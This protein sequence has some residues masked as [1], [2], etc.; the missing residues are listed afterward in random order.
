MHV[1]NSWTRLHVVFMLT[2]EKLCCHVGMKT[3]PTT[4]NQDAS[5]ACTDGADATCRVVFID[6]VP[7]VR[8]GAGCEVWR[9]HVQETAPSR[10]LLN[11][12]PGRLTY[13]GRSVYLTRTEYR[14]FAA[15][16]A[17]SDLCSHA[18]L[19][20]HVWGSGLARERASSLRT[21]LYA[22]RKK[23]HAAQLPDQL[24]EN[25]HGR[26]LRLAEWAR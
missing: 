7:H 22:I 19:A 17:S 5:L 9:S 25:I 15:L 8:V 11:A 3:D 4:H 16:A 24:I 2:A 1:E 18:E 6:G 13:N 14:I 10:L 21:H 26:G 23:L 12:N 20:G